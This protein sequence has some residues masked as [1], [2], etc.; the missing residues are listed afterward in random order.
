MAGHRAQPT[1]QGSP[2][3][4]AICNGLLY[5]PKDFTKL[6]YRNYWDGSFS[7][8]TPKLLWTYTTLTY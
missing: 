8:G 3:K 5:N 7:K 1:N 2:Q 4:T 6:T